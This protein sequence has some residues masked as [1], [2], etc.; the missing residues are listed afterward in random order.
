M[1]LRFDNVF[2]SFRDFQLDLGA[3]GKEEGRTPRSILNLIRVC[4][5]SKLALVNLSQKWR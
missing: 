1:R 4:Y 3:E 5:W 2:C